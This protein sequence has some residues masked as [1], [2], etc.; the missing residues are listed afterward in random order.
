ML[1]TYLKASQRPSMTVTLGGFQHYYPGAFPEPQKLSG[2]CICAKLLQS[3]LT[4][5]NP[6]GCN[7]PG[8][9]VHG[10]FQAKILG[11]VAHLLLQGISSLLTQVSNPHLLLLLNRQVHSLP[12]CP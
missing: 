4:L 2:V 6:M 3:C 8:S 1:W 10:I 9:S 11:W 5:C 7:P 12:L